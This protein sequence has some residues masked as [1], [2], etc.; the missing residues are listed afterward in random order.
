MPG[1]CRRLFVLSPAF[2]L[3][4]NDSMVVI[5]ANWSMT[6]WIAKEPAKTALGLATEGCI[7]VSDRMLISI[8]FLSLELLE[9]LCAEAVDALASWTRVL[10]PDDLL[11]P[12]CL[13]EVNL[14]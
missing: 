12:G 8:L 13:Q 9:M 4:N 14:S 3:R 2:C 7:V 5:C 1:S 10:K 6:C 11:S